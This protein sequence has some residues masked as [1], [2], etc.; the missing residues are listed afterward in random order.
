MNVTPLAKKLIRAILRDLNDRR[1]FRQAW[2]FVDVKVQRH[3][4][5]EL[6]RAV[7]KVLDDEAPAEG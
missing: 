3:I 1:G 2:E 6:Q 4:V 5:R 7:Q